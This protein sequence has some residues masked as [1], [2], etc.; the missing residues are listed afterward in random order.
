MNDTA[1]I[2]STADKI[3][4]MLTEN[5]GRALG[6]SGGAYGRNWERN[7]GRDFAAEESATLDVSWHREGAEFRPHVTLS[8][9]HW[10]NEVL[11]Y[12]AEA[13]ARWQAFAAER[14]ADDHELAIMEAYGPWLA[15]QG[16]E[17]GG[18]YG[19]G[20]PLL[21][22]TYNGECLLS[23]TLQ[24]LFLSI[25][26]TSYVLLQVHGGCDVRGGYTDAVLFEA[27]E[28]VLYYADAT[29]YAEGGDSYWTTTNGWNWYHEGAC[30]HGAGKALHEYLVSFDPAHK[31]D[32]EHVYVDEDNNKAFCPLSGLPLIAER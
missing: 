25:D 20:E 6:D 8:V 18:I 5:T 1:T 22:N 27:D 2:P 21:I 4:D 23:Q 12:D 10:M 3:R 30:G 26:D 24:F 16:H 29:I 15:E 31:G 32:G 7:Q 28:S 11:L 9:Y 17:V 14:R 13:D 19:E